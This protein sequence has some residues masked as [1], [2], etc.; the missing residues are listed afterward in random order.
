MNTFGTFLYIFSFKST[1]M[2]FSSE[3]QKI[4]TKHIIYIFK[5]N[6]KKYDQTLLLLSSKNTKNDSKLK[7]KIIFVIFT[8]RQYYILFKEVFSK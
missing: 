2:S 7:K 3:F 5:L 1:E 8:I 4:E 6:T